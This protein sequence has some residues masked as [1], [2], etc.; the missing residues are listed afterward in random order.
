[1]KLRVEIDLDNDAFAV[2][3]GVETSRLLRQLA[4]VAVMKQLHPGDRFV[5]SDCN[6]N[7]VG[8]AEVSE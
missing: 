6:G 8:Q 3:G 7:A 5:L 1:M 2:G 4:S